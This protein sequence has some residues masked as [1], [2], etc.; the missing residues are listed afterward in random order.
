MSQAQALPTRRVS[1]RWPFRILAALICA[2]G[3]VAIGGTA[4]ALW[5]ESRLVGTGRTLTAL[6]LLVALPGM[7]CLL[8]LAAHATLHGNS[9]QQSSRH[10]WWPFAS[11]RVLFA[12]LVLACFAWR[13]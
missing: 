4:I 1:V 11:E 5:Y 2:A 12:Y 7:L 3:L 8:R 6:R 9:G 10:P 13:S